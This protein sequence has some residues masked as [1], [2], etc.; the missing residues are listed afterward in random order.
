[1][2]HYLLM[3]HRVP[4][5]L[6]LIIALV[7]LAAGPVDADPF[8]S[9]PGARARAMAGA[10]TA[11]A[12]DCSAV[13]YNPSGIAGEKAAATFGWSQAGA[14]RG[15]E[16]ELDADEQAWLVGAQF[17]GED[18][19]AEIAGGLKYGVGI[20][21]LTP[22]TMHYWA[23]DPAGYD[24]AWGQV[25]EGMQIISLPLALSSPE[26]RFKVGGTIEWVRTSV[27]CPEIFY[28]DPYNWAAPFST[29]EA[30]DTGF[31]GSLGALGV[32]VRNE[33]VGFELTLGG[34]Y[35]LDG[36]TDMGAELPSKNGGRAVADFFFDKP[37]SVEIGLAAT[38]A[39]PA[40]ARVI[41]SGQYSTIDWG[42]G[43]A[44]TY[45]RLA[46]GAELTIEKEIAF[47]TQGAFRCGY[48]RSEP[49]GGERVW[50]WPEVSAI[51]Y[52]LGVLAGENIGMD[53][54]FENRSLENDGGLDDDVFLAGVAMTILF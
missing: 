33:K 19:E 18:Q 42:G 34:V 48:Y 27:T 39:L 10:F 8:A 4:A 17:S 36:A 31:S 45:D 11:V 3:G 7:L 43:A 26:G 14:V 5:V 25:N 38:Q 23:H 2:M 15:V 24:V 53:L 22:Y 35:R 51:T 44:H 16:G 13:W 21:Y 9:S 47:I 20:Y 30:S 37:E 29:D 54:S 50:D 40:K 46:A 28:R 32:L 12:D 1:M 49:S 52:G 41:L 6:L